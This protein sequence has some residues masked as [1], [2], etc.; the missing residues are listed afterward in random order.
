MHEIKELSTENPWCDVDTNHE[1]TGRVFVP[2]VGANTETPCH[3]PLL[4]FWRCETRKLEGETNSPMQIRQWRMRSLRE[5][6]Q[7]KSRGV[8]LPKTD[9]DPFVTPATCLVVGVSIVRQVQA[10][11]DHRPAL[12]V[13]LLMENQTYATTSLSEFTEIMVAV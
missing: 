9:A 3:K 6:L 13:V 4:E 10:F 12:H 8:T 7:A 2:N 1:L 5:L 11:I